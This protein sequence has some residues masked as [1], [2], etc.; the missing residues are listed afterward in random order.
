VAIVPFRSDREPIITIPGISIALADVIIAETGADMSRFPS[1]S[2]LASWA[3]ALRDLGFEDLI[4]RITSRSRGRVVAMIVAQTF[5]PSC[6]RA[7]ASVIR[8]ETASSFRA[9][10][11][12]TWPRL[13]VISTAASRR[14]ERPGCGRTLMRRR[15][16]FG[17]GHLRSLTARPK[18]RLVRLERAK[19]RYPV[20]FDVGVRDRLR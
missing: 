15:A 5:A 3:R 17:L 14:H 19:R 13:R 2:H 12:L 18:C 11:R 9:A 4:D 16:D 8:A 1:A 20:V 10:R 6:K 7:L